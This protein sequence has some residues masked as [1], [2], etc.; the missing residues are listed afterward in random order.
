MRPK[1]YP[2]VC[3]YVRRHRLVKVVE[4][5]LPVDFPI[6]GINGVQSARWWCPAKESYLGTIRRP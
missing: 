4:L 3:A 1:G 5:F 2:A 6:I